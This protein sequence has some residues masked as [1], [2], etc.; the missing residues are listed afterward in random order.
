M[1][2]MGIDCMSCIRDFHADYF[3][4]CIDAVLSSGWHTGLSMTKVKRYS[5]QILQYV[6]ILAT[7]YLCVYEARH[8]THPR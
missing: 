5:V 4:A 2:G 3:A 8:N 1:K 7:S 6:R